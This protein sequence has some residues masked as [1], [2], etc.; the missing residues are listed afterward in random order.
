MHVQPALTAS[1][2][3]GLVKL[4]QQIELQLQTE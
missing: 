4:W 1:V 2:L 3:V